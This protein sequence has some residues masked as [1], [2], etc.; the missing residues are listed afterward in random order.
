MATKK[1]KGV[2]HHRWVEHEEFSYIF[3]EPVN[4]EEA[5]LAVND[6]NTTYDSDLTIDCNAVS[7]DGVDVPRV[8]SYSSI[9][10]K[11]KK[12]DSDKKKNDGMGMYGTFFSIDTLSELTGRDI[13]DIDNILNVVKGPA[14][15]QL[16]R[17]AIATM[18]DIVEK[19]AKN[20]K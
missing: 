12:S 1:V 15:H 14:Y 19:E 3:N 4:V 9:P 17:D 7:M 2:K 16:R 13:D 18:K 20:K 11:S 5:R 10:A 8:N 6:V